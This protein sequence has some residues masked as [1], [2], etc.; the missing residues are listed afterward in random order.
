[1]CLATSAS[2]IAPLSKRIWSGN[3]PMRTTRTPRAPSSLRTTLA[4]ANG[5]N[6]AK[7]TTVTFNVSGAYQFG[8]TVTDVNGLTATTT[9]A[10]TVV[11]GSVTGPTE[12]SGGG[13]LSARAAPAT[14]AW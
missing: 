11:V 12:I 14:T 7:N 4:S 9:D 1:M 13:G 2:E 6:D 10:V 5:S 3:V 8:V